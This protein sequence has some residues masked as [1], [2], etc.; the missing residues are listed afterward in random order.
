MLQ[1]FINEGGRLVRARWTEGADLP[2][3]TVWV[4][5]LNPTADEVAAAERCLGQRLPTRAQMAEIEDSSRLRPGAASLHMTVLALVWA[6]TDQPKMAPVS[7]VLAGGRLATV[8]HIDPQP[9]L[10]FRRRVTHQGFVPARAD[11]VMTALIDALLERT[12]N[13][14]RRVGVELEA[15]GQ[16]SFH[17]GIPGRAAPPRD[18]G[19]TLRRL[20]QAGQLV[21]K[22]HESLSSL[23]RVLDFLARG[24]GDAMLSKESR[25]WSRGAVL[26]AKGLT[27]YAQFLVSKVRLLLETTLG[28]IN[29]EQNEIVKILSVASVGLFPPTLIASLCGMNFVAEPGRHWAFGYPLAMLAIIA[30]GL[31][32]MWYF[33]RKRWM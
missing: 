11:S 10:T 6:D 32:P 14:L 25:R 20:G 4:D 5:L 27:E 13:V 19:R 33:R 26:D 7:F 22:A 8:H 2:S 15:M 24:G 12:A 17:R 21:A 31:I 3:A 23:H 16:R 29:V 28:Q 18:D 1:V 30:S 9:F